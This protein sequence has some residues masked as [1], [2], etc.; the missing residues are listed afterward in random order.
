MGRYEK[1][2]LLKPRAGQIWIQLYTG[3]RVI[4]RKGSCKDKVTFTYMD[5]KKG[6]NLVT[7]LFTKRYEYTGNS[8]IG[9]QF[10]KTRIKDV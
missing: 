9:K 2:G 1:V 6:H 8:I 5:A 10:K 3:A 4:I 7:Q